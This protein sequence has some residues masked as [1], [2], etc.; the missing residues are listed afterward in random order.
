[1]WLGII[2]AYSLT[3]LSVLDISLKN[4]E[5]STL[6]FLSCLAFRNNFVL[7]V[8]LYIYYVAIYVR[9]TLKF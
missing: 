5:E 7:I 1:M 6:L 3:T 4:L 8:L 2:I 9:S